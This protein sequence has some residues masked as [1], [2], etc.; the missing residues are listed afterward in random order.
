[1]LDLFGGDVWFVIAQIFG[2]IGLILIDKF[3][4]AAQENFIEAPSNIVLDI[5]FAVCMPRSAKWLRNEWGC[6]SAKFGI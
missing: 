3:P 6:G 1:M 5:C 4:D 2:A